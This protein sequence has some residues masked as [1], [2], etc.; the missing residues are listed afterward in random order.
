[1][2]AN[3]RSCR[4]GLPDGASGHDADTSGDR[5]ERPP[6]RVGQDLT[7][8][9]LEI[10][11]GLL[12]LAVYLLLIAVLSLWVAILFTVPRGLLGAWVL[13]RRANR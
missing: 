9:Q 13:R 10:A 7:S 12:G 4:R 6:K 1:M 11:L 2:T 5:R 8:R 3:R